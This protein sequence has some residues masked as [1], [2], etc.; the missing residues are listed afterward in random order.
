[1]TAVPG[2]RDE[3][4]M[5]LV[6]INEKFT[7]NDIGAFSFFTAFV[8]SQDVDKGRLTLTRT[9]FIE[10]LAKRFDISTTSL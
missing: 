5:V 8:S 2:S 6:V 10:T 3:V 7:T 9:D 1:M 4:L